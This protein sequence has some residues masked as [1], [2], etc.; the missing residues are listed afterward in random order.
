MMPR[1][2]VKVPASD[3]A[4]MRSVWVSA[5][6][7]DAAQSFVRD[8]SAVRQARQPVLP[9][10]VVSGGGEVYSLLAMLDALDAYEGTVVTVALGQAMS[11]G[12]VLFSCG[13]QGH[14]FIAPNA[15]LLLHDVSGIA[16]PGKAD[17]QRVNAQE[18]TR[19]NR[20]LWHR[21]SRNIGKPPD[22]LRSLHRKRNGTDWYLSASAAVRVGLASHVGVPVFEVRQRLDPLLGAGGER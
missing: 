18:A 15:T 16:V 5:F 4:P 13:A 6:D 22:H 2:V 14:R 1:P 19:L 3:A 21:L 11:C 17:E 7:E 9:L 12:A 8:V 20:L 10:I